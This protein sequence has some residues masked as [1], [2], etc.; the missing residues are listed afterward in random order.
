MA[1]Q[2]AANFIDVNFDLFR[3]HSDYED[4]IETEDVIA[5]AQAA[6]R[7]LDDGVPILVPP[8][9]YSLAAGI[10]D[11]R[12]I[13]DALLEAAS[14][15]GGKACGVAEP[16]FG[17]PAMAEIE[18]IAAAGAVALMFSPRAQGC[19]A[20]DHVM[21]EAC[22]QVARCG[23]AAMVRSA[24][25]SINES[26]PRIWELARS[27]EQVRFIV[28]GAFASWENIQLA[29]WNKGGPANV[30]YD[31]SGLVEAHD[32]RFLLEDLGGGRL[33]F[34]SG[35][36]AHD[37]VLRSLVDRCTPPG[38]D[39]DAVLSGNAR[40]LLKLVAEGAIP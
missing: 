18:R 37:P 22:G 39:R 29:R 33:L 28:V 9:Y 34:G 10:A 12:R 13:N 20:N 32:L 19:F 16:R 23:M 26:L 30:T 5:I 2:V 14:R 21:V 17:E 27:C 31:L 40:A 35:G 11:N 6:H 1:G 3:R 7:H 38:E 24:P 15:L 4:F 8:I 25:Y 36:P